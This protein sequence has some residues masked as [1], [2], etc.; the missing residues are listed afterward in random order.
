M[1]LLSL[2]RTFTRKNKKRKKKKERKRRSTTTM[3]GREEATLFVSKMS[4]GIPMKKM[5]AFSR[6][7]IGKS[8]L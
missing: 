5:L 1:L 4:S 2:S 3:Y 8:I 7:D 6:S